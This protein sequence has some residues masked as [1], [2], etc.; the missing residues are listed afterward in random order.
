MEVKVTTNEWLAACPLG[1]ISTN[2]SKTLLQDS[3]SANMPTFGFLKDFR[4]I[5]RGTTLLHPEHAACAASKSPPALGRSYSG[6]FDD[7]G[8]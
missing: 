6:N 1:K 8:G 3:L 4:R 5:C 7:V 2:S